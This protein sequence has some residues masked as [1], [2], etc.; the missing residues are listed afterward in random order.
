MSTITY[1]QPNFQISPDLANASV[2]IEC[3]NNATPVD[4]SYLMKRALE[5]GTRYI[6]RK[7][8]IFESYHKTGLEL[9][10][11]KADCYQAYGEKLGE[12]EFKRITSLGF[13][14]CEYQV[15]L[16]VKV[17]TWFEGLDDDERELVAQKAGNWTAINTLK[18]L[19]KVPVS[20]EWFF[21]LVDLYLE[22]TKKRR[23]YPTGAEVDR[24]TEALKGKRKIG[25]D[26]PLTIIDWVGLVNV[27]DDYVESL[28]F[29]CSL[30]Q[31]RGKALQIAQE[32]GR[33]TVYL[34]DAI[35]AL[36]SLGKKIELGEVAEPKASKKESLEVEF[37]HR[38]Q[39]IEQEKASLQ[40]QLKAAQQQASIESQRAIAAEKQARIDSQ[41]AIEAEEQLQV[42]RK[43]LEIAYSL[44]PPN[45]TVETVDIT[46][47][48]ASTP[49]S[50]EVE[51]E[52]ADT[53]AD[54]EP[55][56]KA[57]IL[58]MRSFVKIIGSARTGVLLGRNDENWWV[59]FPD[60][61]REEFSD[62][63]LEPISPIEITAHDN[64]DSNNEIDTI[65]EIF[66]EQTPQDYLNSEQESSL[67]GLTVKVSGSDGEMVGSILGFDGSD[68]VFVQFRTENGEETVG[69]FPVTEIE[70][71]VNS[72]EY[73]PLQNL[74]CDSSFLNDPQ[75]HLIKCFP[76]RARE[77]GYSSL[78]F[79]KSSERKKAS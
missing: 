49:Q 50:V 8:E 67:K 38:I 47:V 15:D 40:A 70:V 1:P 44:S 76:Q 56:V 64:V 46:P 17:F 12:Q 35:A 66:D 42:M 69:A 65:L 6:K 53:N 14:G 68:D 32:D 63:E 60:G 10:Q 33:E 51:E 71:R 27:C 22:E 48:V 73:S 57:S 25:W 18:K 26:S 77:R 13:N 11:L 74:L 3:I 9:I 21:Y 59:Q 78:A 41:R 43:Q 19:V 45:E 36:E 79:N 29:L 28:N 54:K 5:L 72:L 61:T 16:L 31:A 58:K 34:S 62:G 30:E 2:G 75:A 55:I 37:Q 24:I 39:Q 52:T 4:P 20:M 23:N 7:K